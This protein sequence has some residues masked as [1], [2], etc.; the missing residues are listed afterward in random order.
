MLKP[1]KSLISASML[2]TVLICPLLDLPAIAIE[3]V[4][5]AVLPADTFAPGPTSGQLIT[6]STNGRAVPFVNQQPVQGFSAVLPGPKPGSF[7]VL[8]DNGFGSKGNSPDFVLRFYAV[9]PDFRSVYGGSG[10]V[11]PVD[12][13]SGEKLNSFSPQSFRQLN[14]LRRRVG[15]PIVAEESVYP[16]SITT[17]N[18]DG[19]A[20]NSTIQTNRL[21]TGADFDLES[22][23]RTK[24]GTYWFGDEFGPF[25]LHTSSR[26]HLLEAP[27]PLP[28]FLQL[29]NLPLVQSPDNPA[30]AGLLTDAARIAAANLPRSRGF[31][32]MALNASGTKLYAMLEG[33]LVSDSQRDRLLISEF[34]LARKQYTGR[35][36][37]YKME[38]T[39]EN[40]QAIGELTAINDHEFIVIERDSNQGDPN[41]P[42]FTTP[43]QFKRLYKIDI[44]Q[45]DSQGFVKKELLVDLL[46]IPDPNSIGGNG[47]INGRFTFPFITIE[48]VLP[49]NPK[50]LLV[51]NDN[52]YP[53]S[54]GR[55][56]NQADNTEFIL[57]R[58][59]QPLNLAPALK[60]PH[61]PWHP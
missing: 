38:N 9:K 25:L 55:T 14:D 48:S 49:I 27:I 20:V 53:F 47:T 44:N 33:P 22:F 51:I 46:N 3:L 52:N 54:V 6:G 34:D 36:F 18:P 61:W 28:N 10:Q 40:G 8:A 21:L 35:I 16:G 12:L 43:A 59:D 60:I 13:R 32:G 4:G 45:L 50:T 30:F 15:F 29:G 57:I 19:I 24:D 56:P 31:E 2:S 1:A 7:L 17:T 5:R 58:L 41:N 26:G 23:R 39:T 11:F 42:A 37:S